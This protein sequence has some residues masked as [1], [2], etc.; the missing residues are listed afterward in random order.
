MHLI[1]KYSLNCGISPAKLGKPYI[2]TS[3]YPIPSNKY[4]V[5]HPSSGMSS[6]N[7]SYYQDIIDFIYEETKTTEFEIIQI[8]EEKDAP[9]SKCI[10][11]QGKTNIHQTCFILKNA[12]LF[13]GNDSFSTHVSSA[14]GIPLVSLYSVIQPEVAGPYWNNG[15]QFTIMAPLEGKKPKYSAEDPDRLI[16]KIKPEEV[17]KKISLALPEINSFSN[18]NLESLFFGKGYPRISTEFVP[19][20]LIEINNGTEIPLNIRFDYLDSDISSHNIDSALINLLKRKCGIITSS[21][22]DLAKFKDAN[23][24]QNIISFIFHIEKNLLDSID[25]SIEFISYAKKLGF[26]IKVALIKENFSEEEVSELKFKF[27]N[28]QG[29]TFLNQT[30]WDTCITE[31]T[32]KKINNLTILKSSRIIYS[33]NKVF[34]SKTALSE[35]KPANNFTQ[36]LSDIQDLKALGKELE[37][38]YLYNLNIK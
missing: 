21:P 15:K 34:L 19:D 23:V 8:G 32:R 27:L 24:K 25:K 9:L 12:S 4:I 13:I 36:P 29:I 35:N 30:N 2:Y 1:E 7:Y 31:E 38:C 3:Y 6:K 18:K 37:N 28:I 5:I 33:N 22:F 17:L 14:F 10:N 20:S 11:L 16:D 26:N